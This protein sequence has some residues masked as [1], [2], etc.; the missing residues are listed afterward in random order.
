MEGEVQNYPPAYRDSKKKTISVIQG[1]D[2]DNIQVR[3]VASY[4]EW[5]CLESEFLQM[6]ADNN[7]IKAEEVTHFIKNGLNNISGK[8]LSDQVRSYC[9]KDP[10]EFIWEF[11]WNFIVKA[12]SV[13]PLKTVSPRDL[14]YFGVDK[15]EVEKIKWVSKWVYAY[16]LYWVKQ[17]KETFPLEMSNTL[18]K[19][20]RNWKPKYGALNLTIGVIRHQ[21]KIDHIITDK[22]HFRN[23]WIYES[24][25]K[26]RYKEIQDLLKSIDYKAT[27]N[28]LNI[29]FP[30]PQ[31]LD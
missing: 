5:N 2:N 1:L 17:P 30:T 29:I 20:D 18:D 24:K 16:L 8:N 14:G 21:F 19:I 11:Y 26:K 31:T 23:N 15:G 3:F 13:N 27:H 7:Y 10:E 9:K 25:N 28:P 22:E 6:A 12:Q 4:D